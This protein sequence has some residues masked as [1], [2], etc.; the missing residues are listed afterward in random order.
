VRA[1]AEVVPALLPGA[2]PAGH[3]QRL[4]VEAD[5]TL[6]TDV[7]CPVRLVALRLAAA[8]APQPGTDHPQQQPGSPRRPTESMTADTAYGEAEGRPERPCSA[9]IEVLV[10]PRSS[11][12]RLLRVR[13]RSVTVSG[14]GF[15]YEADREPAG[16]VRSR[17]WT[18]LPAAWRLTVPRQ[19][20]A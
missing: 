6:L 14:R 9:V 3:A 13:A 16:P 17:T 18:V 8:A 4:R 11:A 2:L 20:P 19:P 10:R 5:G 7:D 1:C 15:S 12:D